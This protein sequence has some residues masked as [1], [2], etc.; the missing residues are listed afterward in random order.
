[1]FARGFLQRSALSKSIGGRREALNFSEPELELQ[2]A[3]W[4]S[5]AS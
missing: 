1:M 5:R 3:E 2:V 4:S